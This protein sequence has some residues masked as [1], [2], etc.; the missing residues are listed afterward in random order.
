MPANLTAYAARSS[1]VTGPPTVAH[2]R[3]SG[4]ASA[5]RLTRC[6]ALVSGKP[7]IE[8]RGAAVVDRR[9]ARFAFGV[10]AVTRFGGLALGMVA[11][12][13]SRTRG[14]GFFDSA[15]DVAKTPVVG[16]HATGNSRALAG[17]YVAVRFAADGLEASQWAFARRRRREIGNGGRMDGAVAEVA[18]RADATLQGWR[19][20]GTGAASDGQEEEDQPAETRDLVG[21]P[22]TAARFRGTIEK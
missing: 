5:P 22:Y 15:V 8:H 19:W 10:A 17:W 11:A 7:A 4:A 2:V 13:R 20:G 16:N 6:D 3:G 14:D 9:V 12:M 18:L 21:H 1:A